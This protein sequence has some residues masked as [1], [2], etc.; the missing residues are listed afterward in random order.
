M[1]RQATG[2]ERGSAMVMAVFVLFLLAST[3][4]ALLFLSHSEAEASKASLRASQAFYI[5][6]GSVE[7][8]RQRIYDLN[9][10]NE[11]DDDLDTA[12]GAND[13]I[14]LIDP[15]ALQPVYDANGVF[16]G[17][18]GAG[19]DVP[20][21]ALQGVNGGT[22]LAY[23]TNDP[24]EDPDGRAQ[25]TDANDRLSL[26]GVGAGTDRSFEVVEAIIERRPPIPLA[27]PSTITMLGPPPNFAS[28]TS[29]VK[30]YVGNDCEGTSF[31]G[32]PGL[33]V[34]IVGAIGDAAEAQIE[35][36]IEPL[37]DFIIN[38]EDGNP[39]TD[40]D[41]VANLLDGDEP[42]LSGPGAIPFDPAWNDCATLQAMLED[43]RDRAD[44]VC[45]TGT[46]QFPDYGPDT[47]IFI[48]GDYNLGPSESGGQGVLV[49]TGE[50]VLSGRTDWSGLIL[51]VG[52]GQYRMNGSGNGE[53]IGGML[54][55][56]I[57]G[58][59]NVY[60]TGD[61]CQSGSGGMGQTTFD[62]RGGGNAMTTY[63]STALTNTNVRPYQ[64]VEFLQH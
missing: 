45:R 34:P 8:A 17:V 12:A 38:D 27:P 31:T 56:D 40:E 25:Q 50:L 11:F 16:T 20:L 35:P 26:I 54:L 2:R 47:L 44:E 15:E 5:A 64:I 49:C 52:E 48:E 55:A 24:L 46:C 3:G 32:E 4:I 13:T 58:P 42:S 28:A 10:L 37:P 29:K 21:I 43:L 30:D 39:L 23:L 14:D 22:I 63:C 61:D 51:V 60:G 7:A 36:G 57:A 33:Y 1:T 6:E 41:V 53:V 59:D 62:E 9:G 18:T 19:D